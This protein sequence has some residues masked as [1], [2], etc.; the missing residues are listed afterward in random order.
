MVIETVAVPNIGH[1]FAIFM[2]TFE[3]NLGESHCL[4][5]ILTLIECF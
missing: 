2:L 4:S 5:L 1:C 3:N